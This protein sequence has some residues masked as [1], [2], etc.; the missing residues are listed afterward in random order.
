MTDWIFP[1]ICLA[2]GFIGLALFLSTV[3][4]FMETAI[5]PFWIFIKFGLSIVLVL[6]CCL[7]INSFFRI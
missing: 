5:S 7:G 4:E 6:V 1:V 3:K 2:I